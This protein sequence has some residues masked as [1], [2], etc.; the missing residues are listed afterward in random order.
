MTSPCSV[1]RPL[2][3]HDAPPSRRVTS[4][5]FVTF[6]AP[7]LFGFY[8]FLA[9]YLGRRLGIA[10]ELVVGSSYDELAAADVA[11]VCGLPYVESQLAGESPVEPIAAPVLRGPRYRGRPVYFSDVVVHHASPHTSFADLRGRTW[12]YNEPHSQSGYGI[13]RYFLAES[14][15]T[16]GYFSRVIEAGWHEKAVR[17]VSIG[18]VDAAA[19]DS[20]VLAVMQRDAPELTATLRTI[21]TLGPSTIQPVVA[22][23][24]LPARL[25]RER[26]RLFVSLAD[27]P[28]AQRPLTHALV[29]RFTPVRDGDY[30]D[31]R[32]MRNVAASA[33]CLTLR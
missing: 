25:K 16:S 22:A 10:T 20:H 13:T 8:E 28:A 21:H 7:N 32:R 3:R 24:R 14:G 18:E 23:R 2:R 30:D 1:L 5:R 26:R 11:F 4:L 33:G 27:D 12:A 9:T 31:I 6:L 17:M 19:I 29:E 15:E